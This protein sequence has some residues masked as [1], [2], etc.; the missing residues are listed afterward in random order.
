MRAS[1]FA[2]ILAGI[3]F[4]T[5]AI[6]AMTG[7]YAVGAIIAVGSVSWWICRGQFLKGWVGPDFDDLRRKEASLEELTNY[8]KYPSGESVP[9]SERPRVLQ[10]LRDIREQIYDH[11]MNPRH[12]S[13][14]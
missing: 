10:R 7:S 12:Q 6:V 2:E 9:S 8:W 4:F 13:R 5:G 1:A 14:G 11:P 3:G